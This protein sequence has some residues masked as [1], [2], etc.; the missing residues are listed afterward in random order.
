MSDKIEYSVVDSTSAIVNNFISLEAFYDSLKVGCSYLIDGNAE[1]PAL[2]IVDTTANPSIVRL[3]S[4]ARIFNAMRKNVKSLSSILEGASDMIVEQVTLVPPLNYN[5]SNGVRLDIDL[6]ASEWRATN[7]LWYYNPW[8][9]IPRTENA[10][11]MDPYGHDI[12][13]R[14]VV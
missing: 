8:T 4:A 13:P 6:S 7:E 1:Y 5:P 9:G 14:S 2:C 10:I 12:K 11:K 3:I